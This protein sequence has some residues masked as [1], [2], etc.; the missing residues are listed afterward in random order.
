MDMRKADQERCCGPSGKAEDAN[1]EKVANYERRINSVI[2]FHDKTACVNPC[3][4]LPSIGLK[5]FTRH[6]RDMTVVIRQIWEMG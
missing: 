2:R 4:G 6:L 3:I 5:N 1:G